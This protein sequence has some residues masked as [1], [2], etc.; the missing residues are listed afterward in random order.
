MYTD[1]HTHIEERVGQFADASSS[2][3]RLSVVLH[4]HVHFLRTSL[5]LSSYLPSS[6]LRVKGRMQLESIKRLIAKD[7]GVSCCR[8]HFE[9]VKTLE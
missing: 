1:T 5:L 9:S 4:E 8:L 7:F 3:K 6:S 2:A